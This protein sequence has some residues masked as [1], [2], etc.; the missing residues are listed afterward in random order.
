MPQQVS[1]SPVDSGRFCMTVIA[2]AA[3]AAAAVVVVRFDHLV[4]LRPLARI[5]IIVYIL[6]VSF[7]SFRSMFATF[8]CW[9][10]LV[11]FSGISSF[12]YGFYYEGKRVCL[13]LRQ[14]KIALERRANEI[15]ICLTRRLFG[16]VR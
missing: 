10:R 8:S 15:K 9:P 11:I 13:L 4:F 16:E 3:T 1:A 12:H 6:L 5:Y 2:D 7:Q 14:N